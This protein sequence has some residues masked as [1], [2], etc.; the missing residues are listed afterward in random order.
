MH[1]N[2][3]TKLGG[4]GHLKPVQFALSMSPSAQTSLSLPDLAGIHYQQREGLRGSGGLPWKRLPRGQRRSDTPGS[5]CNSRIASHLTANFWNYSIFTFSRALESCWATDIAY[6]GFKAASIRLPDSHPKGIQLL[7]HPTYRKTVCHENNRVRTGLFKQKKWF[8][9][10]ERRQLTPAT[11]KK[12]MPE[13]WLH[14]K[15]H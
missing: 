15:T 3:P 4:G 8:S 1:I 11:I 2:R 9:V 12:G 14:A 5:T 13:V 6:L 7:V 10:F